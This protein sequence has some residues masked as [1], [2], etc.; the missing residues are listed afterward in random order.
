M[1]MKKKLQSLD[2]PKRQLAPHPSPFP[3]PGISLPGHQMEHCVTAMLDRIWPGL[4]NEL[5]LFCFIS[6]TSVTLP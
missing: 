3:L 6:H 4:E 1:A 5:L 2:R